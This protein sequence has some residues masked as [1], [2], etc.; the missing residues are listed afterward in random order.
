MILMIVCV[1]CLRNTKQSS[2]HCCHTSPWTPWIL[3][4]CKTLVLV[5]VRDIVVK[6]HCIVKFTEHYRPTVYIVLYS[7]YGC[8]FWHMRLQSKNC[9]FK[10]RSKIVDVPFYINYCSLQLRLQI[11]LIVGAQ[12]HAGK[13]TIIRWYMD[14]TKAIYLCAMLSP[15]HFEKK[16]K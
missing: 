4:A 16:G 13:S 7:I 9:I 8:A 10:K 6:N 11:H 2:H 3:Y 15:I 1:L 12:A 5:G 14:R